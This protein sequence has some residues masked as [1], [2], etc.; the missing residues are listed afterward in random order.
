[1]MLISKEKLF[2]III[3][4]IKDLRRIVSLLYNDEI[5]KVLL[6][7]IEKVYNSNYPLNRETQLNLY[8]IMEKYLFIQEINIAE[9]KKKLQF[10]K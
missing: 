6:S 7:R 9:L 4:D 10:I 1:M 3:K 8:D 5:K 2:N